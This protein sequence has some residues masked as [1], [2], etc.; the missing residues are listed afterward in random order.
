MKVTQHIYTADITGESG[1]EVFDNITEMRKVVT[2]AELAKLKPHL[3]VH[4]NKVKKKYLKRQ[5]DGTVLLV[6]EYR[7]GGGSTEKLPAD[8]QGGQQQ[9]TSGHRDIIEAIRSAGEADNAACSRCTFRG[10]ENSE[11]R[12]DEKLSGRNDTQRHAQ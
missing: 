8:S 10:W 6:K 1:Q 2:I 11:R 7:D 9:L 3:K 5:P 12:Y 4:S